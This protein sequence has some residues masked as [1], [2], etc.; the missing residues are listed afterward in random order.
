MFLVDKIVNVGIGQCG[1]NFVRE[2]ENFGYGSF[3][4]NS[5][6]EDLD[7]INT[8]KKNKYHIKA[9]KGM[10]K[11]RQMAK[12]CILSNGNAENIADTIHEQNSMAD[13]IFIYY[14]VSGGTGGTMGNFIAMALADLYPEKT[15][16]VVAILPKSNEDIGLQANAIESLKHLKQLLE[17]GVITQLHLLDNNSR[18]DIFSINKDFAICFNRFV[19]FNEITEKGN[20]DEEERERLLIHQGMGVILEFA[21]E[22]FGNGL[23][24]ACDKA[25]YAEW[26]K[27]PD[28]HGLI[29]NQKQNV[30]VNR[31]LIRDVL[32]MATYTH[33]STWDDE[34][35]VLLAVG[36]SFNENILTKMNANAQS[37]LEK[38]KN[39]EEQSKKDKMEEVE[40][41]TSSIM[42]NVVK[43]R[44]PSSSQTTNNSPRRRG[45]KRASSVLDKY[46]NM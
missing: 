43:K 17:D 37:L 4:V 31:E 10:A 29:L 20:L 6:L 14:S 44:V 35:N 5:S 32:G 46:R 24:D 34:S 27:D 7:T 36:M 41:D 19:S 3:Y 13:I 23:S 39:I 25:M 42:K 28:L 8:N 16:N 1:S 11:D 22:D 21:S 45:E 2:L 26:L 38:K 12:E 40:F 33:Y 9:S 15:I 18:E 30:D